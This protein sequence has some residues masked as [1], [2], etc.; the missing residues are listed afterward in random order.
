MN[1]ASARPGIALI[2]VVL[3]MLVVE[4]AIAAALYV[5]LQERLAT[6]ATVLR[7]RARLAAESGVAATLAGWDADAAAALE[8]DGDLES[9]AGPSP[10]GGRMVTRVERTGPSGFRIVAHGTVDGASGVAAAATAT[11]LLQTYPPAA[12]GLAFPAAVTGMTAVEVGGAADVT[13]ASAAPSHGGCATDADS[14]MSAAIG[15]PG[16]AIA[17]PPA[18][19]AA[20]APDGAVVG[21]PPIHRSAVGT[22]SSAFASLAGLSI[23]MLAAL[24]DRTESG[25]LTLTP[26]ALADVCD[27]GAPGNW[28]APASP[29]HPCSRYA[30][31][32]FAPGDLTLVAGDGQGVLVVA[33]NLAVDSASTF[34]GGILVLGTAHIAGR[35]IGGIRVAGR[36]RI[37]GEVRHDGCALWR[38]TVHSPALA[39]PYRPRRWR[40]PGS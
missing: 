17:I 16:P 9:A 37:D 24:A 29:E 10:G 12:L 18:A 22:D 5:A 3:A 23:P 32:V 11:A 31:L 39:G 13:G 36:I 15:G 21:A 7:E 27:V 25:S 1:R 2:G 26:S 38:A 40:L 33:G 28:G 35:V 19:T 14:I 20:L 6:G 34:H 4:A 30:P 8:I